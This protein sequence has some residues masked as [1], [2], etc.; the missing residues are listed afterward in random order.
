LCTKC[1]SRLQAAGV[2]YKPRPGR[3]CSTVCS[4]WALL[5]CSSCV[6]EGSVRH[7]RL[8]MRQSDLAYG[9]AVLLPLVR[10]VAGRLREDR[11]TP[12]YTVP[13]AWLGCR[14]ELLEFACSRWRCMS[15]DVLELVR[16][17]PM[18]GGE[19]LCQVAVSDNMF[20]ADAMV[21]DAV[22]FEEMKV[23]ELKDELLARGA[24]RTGAKGV[25]QQRL[26]TH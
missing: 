20:A 11:S 12:P 24:S 5:V 6:G 8:S 23:K 19:P 1:C 25:L 3:C 15:E 10:D 16:L 9:E 7:P 2:S 4:M 17:E 13:L 26:H 22:D 21:G 14:A 18:S